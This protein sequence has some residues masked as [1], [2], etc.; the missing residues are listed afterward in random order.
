MAENCGK[1]REGWTCTHPKGH[2]GLHVAAGINGTAYAVWVE[3]IK[4][5]F[6][7]VNGYNG[8]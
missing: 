6:H 5:T 4:G 2:T 3:G 8:G 1:T 7:F